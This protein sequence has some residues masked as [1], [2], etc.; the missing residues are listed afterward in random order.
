MGWAVVIK[1]DEE[2]WVEEIEQIVEDMPDEFRGFIPRKEHMRQPNGFPTYATIGIPNDNTIEITGSYIM[3]T[4]EKSSRFVKYLMDELKLLN[5]KNVTFE[6]DETDCKCFYNLE[7]TIK[8]L[9]EIDKKE[10]LHESIQ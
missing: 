2:I 7:D 1:C 8:A 3:T 10:N 6:I 5:H 9:L 4:A